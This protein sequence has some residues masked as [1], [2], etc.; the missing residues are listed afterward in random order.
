M[1]RHV[2][3]PSAEEDVDEILK[4][5]AEHFGEAASLRYESLIVQGIADIVENPHRT[6]V[7]RR[8]EV[9]PEART[10][11]LQNSRHH[12]PADLGRVQVPRHFLLFRVRD[13]G[14]VEVG[15]VLHD[16]MDWSR[17]LPAGYSAGEAD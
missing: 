15:R 2:L 5:S 13:D 4:W 1:L 12:I 14:V 9:V 16:S 17:H 3:S 8:V 6:G 11:H 10:Y 7:H